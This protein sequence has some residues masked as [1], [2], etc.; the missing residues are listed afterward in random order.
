MSYLP[1]SIIEVLSGNPTIID[2]IVLA[3][4]DCIIASYRFEGLIRETLNLEPKTED[5]FANVNR[6]VNSDKTNKPESSQ[7]SELI[8]TVFI[9]NVQI[10]PA[11]RQVLPSK[12]DELMSIPANDL[13]SR[14]ID[15]IQ[16]LYLS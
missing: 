11:L 16:R 13:I 1:V 6:V 8:N 14:R 3:L 15:R 5:R 12:I 9:D 7:N 10:I 4:A 2:S